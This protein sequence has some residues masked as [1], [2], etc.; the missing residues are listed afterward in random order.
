MKHPLWLVM[1]TALTLSGCSMVPDFMRPDLPTT[2]EWPTG[3]AYEDAQNTVS[4][5]S[6]SLL[7]EVGWKDFFKDE[8]LRSLVETSLTNNRDLRMAMANVEVVRAQWQ[9][10]R[11]DLVPTVN[12]AADGSRQRG[13][14]TN[15]MGY[16]LTSRYSVN[17]ATA[18]W[19]LDLWGRVRALN[20]AALEQFFA[21]QEARRVTQIS[22]IAEIANA[23]LLLLSD[24]QLLALTE[25]TL[26]AQE[27]SYNLIMESFMLGIG[28]Q[29]D[30]AQARTSVETA[31]VNRALYQRLVAQDRNALELLVGIPLT[32]EMLKGQRLA[33]EDFLADLPVGLP[34]DLLLLRPDIRQAEHLMKSANANIG[35]ARAAFFPKISLTGSFGTASLGLNN[36]FE[37]G[38]A[39]WAFAPQVSIPIFD[40]GRTQSGLDM[41]KASYDMMLA[42]YEKIIQT[43]FR[44]VADNL[45]ARGTLGK[46]LEAQTALVAATQTSYDL[47]FARYRAGVDSYLNVL[48][49]QRSLYAA[50]QNEISLQMQR[51]A[52]LVNLY[53]S[54]GGGTLSVTGVEEAEEE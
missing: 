11:A 20:E 15:G 53:R 30:V 9:I 31:R 10:Q 25:E 22:L 43:A 37:G 41:A 24:R 3:V 45:A 40:L 16:G 14:M 8:T 6:E 1:T 2:A 35:A 28:S 32:E 44:E 33:P 27:Q 36:L 23:W 13:P 19:E 49:A 39:A 21:S 5:E 42:Q 4:T 7:A 46:Q 52:N 26:A 51:L 50:Q 34:S 17:L 29:L 12:A 18:S 48:D 38:T 54:L 47:S